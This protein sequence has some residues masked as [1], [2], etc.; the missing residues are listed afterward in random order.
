MKKLRVFEAFSGYGSQSIALRNLGIDYEVVAISEI[1]KY[2][3]QAYTAIHGEVNNLGDI[4]Q[5]DTNNIP[6]HD[7]FTYSFP[8]QDISRSGNEESLIEDSGTRSS[9]LWECKKVIGTKKPKYL[10]MENVKNLVS[11]KHKPYFD[12]W[13]EWLESQGYKSDWKVLNSKDYGIPQG[14]ERIFVISKLNDDIEF[15]KH[16]VKTGNIQ[17]LLDQDVDIKNIPSCERAFNNEIEEIFESDKRLHRCKVK[18]NFQ[19]CTVGI[20]VSPTICIKSGTTHTLQYKFKNGKELKNEI[21]SML[22]KVDD[23]YFISKNC[24]NKMIG[25]VDNEDILL[26]FNQ[27]TEL[28]KNDD[29]NLYVDM[30][31]I[32]CKIRKMTPREVFRFM[33]LCESD[34]QKLIDTG[35]SNAQL[36][37]L[38]GN[39]IVVQVLESIFKDMLL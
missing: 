17:D 18:S 38:A 31:H 13:L 29:E 5:I 28:D 11:K 19:E 27:L 16:E 10:L 33:G 37:K 24:I 26:I 15:T 7:L 34:I 12:K 30:I 35:I 9:L 36:Y 25:S 4:S 22:N 23:R 2:A 39:S 21:L 32:M 14:R 20:N 8:C 1:D 3:I 6:D